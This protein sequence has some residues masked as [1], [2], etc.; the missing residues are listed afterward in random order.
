M[1][2]Q[3][4]KSHRLLLQALLM[5]ANLAFSASNAF[6]IGT[7]DDMVQ[8]PTTREFR[9]LDRNSD[10]KLSSTETKA[11]SDFTQNFSRAD[12]NHDGTLSLEEYGTYKSAVQ[13]AR[14]EEFLDDSSITA[15]VK[16]EILKDNGIKGISISVETYRGHVIL[17]GFVDNPQQAQRAVQIASGIRGVS[18]VKNSLVVKN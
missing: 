18:A 3:A 17:S 9:Q 6:A 7:Q 4:K 14:M 15:K 11:D 2:T 13:K 16:A 8:S 1:N 12:T 5:A 10:N